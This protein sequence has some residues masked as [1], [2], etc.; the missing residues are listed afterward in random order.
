MCT[1]HD[2]TTKY[3]LP[4]IKRTFLGFQIGT[5]T[6]ILLSFMISGVLNPYLVYYYHHNKIPNLGHFFYQVLSLTNFLA[7]LI[8]GPYYIWWWISGI[9][10]LTRLDGMISGLVLTLIMMSSTTT[11]Y[12]SGAK[13]LALRYPFYVMSRR[14]KWALKG[15]LMLFS[16]A[17]LTFEIYGMVASE[18][19]FLDA[20]MMFPLFVISV[21]KKTLKPVCFFEGLY[22][23]ILEQYKGG[24]EPEE[25][26]FKIHVLVFFLTAS[27]SW[28]LSGLVV[29]EMRKMR[30]AGSQRQANNCKSGVVTTLLLNFGNVLNAVFSAWDLFARLNFSA[31]MISST[32]TLVFFPMMLCCFSPLIIILRGSKIK[33]HI[34]ASFA[35]AKKVTH[36]TMSRVF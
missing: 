28:I 16:L 35:R 22:K 10:C 6:L 4:D 11:V 33:K 14:V 31:T 34:T 13:V 36:S 21:D 5:C 29:W 32:V 17:I 8:Y 2:Q 25:E 30:G 20:K 9:S 24:E 7:L 26:L 27:L 19:C 15:S 18:K 23:L 1:V 12:L 3:T